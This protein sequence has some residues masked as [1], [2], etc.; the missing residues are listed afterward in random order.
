MSHLYDKII[1]V[2][3]MQINRLLELVYILL[4]RKSVPAR[5]LAEL[6]GVS[7]RTIYRDIDTLSL[8]G[9]PIYTEKGKGGGVTLLPN[10]VLNKSILS[11]QEQNEILT[12]LHGLSNMRVSEAGQVL[13]K[14]STIFNKTAINWLHVDFSDWS[15]LNDYFNDFKTAILEQRIV[16]FDYYNSYG[17]KT[18]RHIE[19]I[20]LWFKSK[21]WYLKG[22]CLTKQSM[23][24]YKLSRVKNLIVTDNYF[25][26]QDLSDTQDI[27]ASS[28]EQEQSEILIKLRI[29]PE[30]KYRLFDD[31]KEED[32]EEQSDGS[33]ILTVSLPE[34]NWVYSFVLSFGEY[35]EVL[36]PE[37][38]RKTIKDKVKKMSA[39]Y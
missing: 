1:L 22:F 33:F 12:A 39:R 13:Q 5:E 3:N 20:Q 10:S 24:V 27:S 29:W 28:N 23:R 6:L 9:I 19:P 35:A 11:E 26:E 36:E 38:L 15:G 4:H 18:F 30:M 34:D 31:F 37:H 25:L 8:A 21:T 32:I 17:D 7:R 14:L 16:E 2:M